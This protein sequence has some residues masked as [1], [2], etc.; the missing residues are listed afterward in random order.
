MLRYLSTYIA[1]HLT[2][3]PL[4]II[5]FGYPVAVSAAEGDTPRALV[6]RLPGG[7]PKIIDPL[8]ASMGKTSRFQ[9]V[10]LEGLF[11]LM[12]Q[13]DDRDDIKKTASREMER[14]R[15][16]LLALKHDQADKHLHTSRQTMETGFVRYY[17]P[18]LLAQVYI[19]L[20]VAATNRA[21]PDQATEFFTRVRHLAPKTKLD[22]H[23]SPQVRTTFARTAL[24]LPPAP[25]PSP[26]EMQK[27]LSLARADVALVISHETTGTADGRIKGVIYERQKNAY[28][29]TATFPLTHQGA[30]ASSVLEDIGRQM[31]DQLA[32][33]ASDESMTLVTADSRTDDESPP[34][35]GRW[36]TWVG[37]GAIVAAAVVVP[38]VMTSSDHVELKVRW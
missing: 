8:V 29:D 14:G 37:I 31:G 9:V 36:Y 35:Y 33:A 20:G 21:R 7:D 38:L 18:R 5:A 10:L 28:T 11:P 1:R 27:L 22:A 32:L 3:L 23:Y 16:A 6:V 13:A 15:A 17:Q 19:L 25:A 4:G 12:R 30:M 24:D 2:L 34:W 26:K